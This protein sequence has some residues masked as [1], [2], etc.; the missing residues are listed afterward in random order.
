MTK[1]LPDTLTDLRTIAANPE[2]PYPTIRHASNNNLLYPLD[3]KEGTVATITVEGLQDAPVTLYWVIKD[4][5]LPTFQPIVVTGSSRDSVEVQIP[6][7][8]VSTCIGH[9]V[10]IWYTAK[11]S[12]RV[13]ESLVL[14]LEIQDV[15]EADLRAS[16]PVFEHAK[17]NSPTDPTV[18]LDM[19]KFQGDETIS[20]KA[21]PMIQAGQ[22][23]FIT[24]A[25][26]QHVTPYQFIWVAF[27]HLVTEA[28][29][30]AD[31]VF[32]FTLSRAWM[33]RRMDYSSLTTHL[34]VIWD[35]VD[36][37]LPVP[38][39]PVHE[40]P[41]PLNA[42]DFHLRTT[43][44]LRVD[45]ALDL[46]PPHLKESV[47][48][49]E[50]G[51]MVNPVNTVK[52]AHIVITYDGIEAGD[53]VCPA[54][55]GTSGPGSPVLECRTVQDNETSLEFVVP[56]SAISANFGQPI[57]LTY[58]VSVNGIEVT[59][60]ERVVNVLN[61]SR[62]PLPEVEQATG[63]TLDLNTF[64]GDAD[65]SVIPWPYITLE[66][67][68]WLWVTGELEDGTPYS[69]EVLEGVPVSAQWLAE[70]VNTPLPRNEL[71]K[72][73]DCQPFHV[74][75]AV[76]FNGLKDKASATKFPLLTL[77]M[78]QE[79]LVLPVPAVL[80]AVGSD[81]TIWNG[82]D[83]VTVRVAYER[84]SEHQTI[85]VQWT[86]PDGT[87]LSLAPKTGNREAGHVDF[88]IP[89]EAVI[90]GAGKQTLIRYTVTSACKMASSE[91]LTLNIS[92][93]VR[94]PT[95]VV[96]QA[97]PPATQNGILDI[98]TFAGDATITVNDNTYEEAWW[99]ALAGQRVWLRGDGT[100]KSGA[101]YT[102]NVYL[103]TVI[104]PAEV[105]A[106]L[107]A[108]L[109][110]TELLMLKNESP[111]IFTCK[112]T[113]DGSTH[114]NQA[115]VFP[116]LQ[117]IVRSGFKDF[118]PFTAGWNGWIAG[119]AANGEMKSYHHQGKSCVA[120]GTASTG[121]VG[122]VLYKDLTGLEA[123]AQYDFSLLACTL[124]GAAPLPKLSLKTRETE[125]VTTIKTFN[126]RS[127]TPLKGSF[128]ATATSMRLEIHGHEPQ[129][130]TGNDYA[131][132]DI[133]ITG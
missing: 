32:R 100:L 3:A 22:R 74:H 20:L 12:G 76:N 73:A 107:T 8:Y 119:S 85:N 65:A 61:V 94:L 5:A 86:Q 105:Y 17:P 77:G 131:I 109:K 68:C 108:A 18:V 46:P 78:V 33:G 29:A 114:E 31:H 113:A 118:T 35:G 16:L 47:D 54:F 112:V 30:T 52:G 14:E 60:P 11:V 101:P 92:G 44:L 93:P 25:G 127:W 34:G 129:G 45:P 48:C 124:N 50:Q 55:I 90:H 2:L 42:Q 53:I 19:F 95:P 23:L 9:T 38:N 66:Q 75:F 69:F 89:R 82:R 83:G 37:I 91:T 123:G 111:L 99:F 80:Q 1:R 96:P 26:D 49:A 63:K 13:K 43:T 128:I 130:A 62:L 132:T 133:L 40:N 72:L 125:N 103:G 98:R 110:R 120:N 104:T 79:N 67:P 88:D 41:L 24:I 121:G 4:Q 7:E 115:V 122:V 117:L 87:H 56:A 102:I 6:W 15:R 106:G 21:W 28:E 36:P 71:Q 57:T 84:I 116:V 64:A 126:S 10:L 81:L 51:W 70:G 58:T 59:S 39:D 97:T 27:D